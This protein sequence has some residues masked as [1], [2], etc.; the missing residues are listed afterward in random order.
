MRCIRA[1]TFPVNATSSGSPGRG[2][3]TQSMTFLSTA[4]IELLYSGQDEQQ[5]LVTFEQ[6]V[7]PLRVFGLTG[8]SFQVTVIERQRKVHEI[9]QRHLTARLACRFRRDTN[10][11][12]VERIPARAPRKGKYFFHS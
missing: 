9:D 6:L 3:E 12:L 7:Q 2:R 8:G 5:R 4:V 10:Q 1:A 11:L